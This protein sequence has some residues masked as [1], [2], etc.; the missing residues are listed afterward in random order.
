[1]YFVSKVLSDS[2]TRYS[3]MQKLMYVVMMTKR[4]LRH[5][6][7]THP[8]T[9]VSNYPLGEVIQNPETKGR[10]A[11]WALELMG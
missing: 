11:K 6:F 2:K 4:K 8:I 7:D 3:Q 9:V 10:I 1:M 5:Y